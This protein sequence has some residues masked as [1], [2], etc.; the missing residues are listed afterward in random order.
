[1]SRAVTVG[2]GQRFRS[3]SKRISSRGEV[4]WRLSGC[5]SAT[6]R[7]RSSRSK[8][9]ATVVVSLSGRGVFELFGCIPTI[10]RIGLGRNRCFE[11]QNVFGILRIRGQVDSDVNALGI[12]GGL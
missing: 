4:C 7:S 5:S 11:F 10:D 1:M 9:V 8:I 12:I 3:Q 2:L 6:G